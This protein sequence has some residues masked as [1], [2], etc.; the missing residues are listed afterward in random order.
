MRILTAGEKTALAAPQKRI[1]YL[2]AINVLDDPIYLCTAR[3]SL[4]VN[5]I[6]WQGAGKLLDIGLP[7]ESAG[8]A[9]N[10]ATLRLSG[11]DAALISLA[12]NEDIENTSVTIY[13]ATFDPDT[14]QIIGYHV[15][16]RRVIGQVRILPP[17]SA[18]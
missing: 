8:I 7:K 17:S 18:Q 10:K 1:A 11:L 14:R 3:Y 12:L 4:T 13:L 15:H 16:T 5:G 9:A 6:E 2:V